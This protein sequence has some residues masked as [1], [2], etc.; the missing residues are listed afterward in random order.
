[1]Y[2]GNEVLSDRFRVIPE[3]LL[4]NELISGQRLKSIKKTIT[5]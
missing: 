5:H 2:V 3:K 4:S 1:M